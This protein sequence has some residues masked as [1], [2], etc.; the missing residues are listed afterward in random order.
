MGEQHPPILME[1]AGVQYDLRLSKK[2]QIG[3][4]RGEVLWE[5]FNLFNTVNFN[6]YQGNQSA[7]PGKTVTGIPTGFGRPRQAFDA[8]QA[9][10]GFKL[11]F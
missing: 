2:V 3:K 1:R 8:F 11:T 4:A 10:L 6:N 5:M 9:Q 7:A